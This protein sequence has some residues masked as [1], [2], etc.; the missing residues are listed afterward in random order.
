MRTRIFNTLVPLLDHG[1][2]ADYGPTGHHDR[3]HFIRVAY[4]AMRG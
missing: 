2:V 3:S 4:P 1:K